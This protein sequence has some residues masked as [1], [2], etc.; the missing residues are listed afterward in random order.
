MYCINNCAV[1]FVLV[2][3]YLFA[4]LHSKDFMTD[5]ARE[6]QLKV[7]CST[8][9]PSTEDVTDADAADHDTPSEQFSDLICANDSNEPLGELKSMKN[10]LFILIFCCCCYYY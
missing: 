3:L 1:I 2:F 6:I 4:L 7:S 10:R 8:S 9:S 5:N